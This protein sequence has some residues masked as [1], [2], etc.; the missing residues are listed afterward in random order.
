M[1]QI[2]GMVRPLNRESRIAAIT[3]SISAPRGVP[4]A[5]CRTWAELAGS[6]SS[7]SSSRASARCSG[8]A[9][10]GLAL[11]VLVPEQ[12]AGFVIEA[13][14]EIGCGGHLGF[15]DQRRPAL[16]LLGWRQKQPIE[17]HFA[18]LDHRSRKGVALHLFQQLGHQGLEPIT[19]L[20]EQPEKEFV[21][22][23]H[24]RKGGLINL[25]SH[26]TQQWIHRGAGDHQSGSGPFWHFR[27]KGASKAAQGTVA[28]VARADGV[29]GG[30]EVAPQPRAPK[31]P[32]HHPEPKLTQAIG[33][34]VLGPIALFSSYDHICFA[35]RTIPI[36]QRKILLSARVNLDPT[37]TNRARLR[38][39]LALIA[40]GRPA[41]QMCGDEGLSSQCLAG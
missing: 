18:L 4:A 7:F 2:S 26:L 33:G 9:A 22:G 16:E 5:C 24:R 39:F 10:Q 38:T 32:S 11:A 27:W 36:P 35:R 19:A 15:Q 25:G 13:Q 21:A 12:Q 41:E 20:L 37:D 29:A 1:A 34:V 40:G 23:N 8:G 28:A 3:S 6:C 31:P 14:E 17:P 30:D